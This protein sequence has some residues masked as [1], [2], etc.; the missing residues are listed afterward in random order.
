MPRSLHGGRH[1]LGQNFL[2]HRP[3]V[4]R[5]ASLV[6]RS[7]G[8]ILEIGAGDGALTRALA[9]L[10]RPLTAIEIDEHR[11][12]E[13]RRS[14]G[15]VRVEHADALRYPLLAPVLV[16]NIPFHLTTPL[17]RRLL[18]TGAWERAILLTQW[19]VARKRAGVGGGTMLTA[20]TAPWFSF[21]LHGR[22]PSWCFRPRPS[23][24]GG[25]LGISRRE[26]P[27]VAAAERG[28]YERFVR[29]LF[30]GRGRGLGGALTHAARLSR[31]DALRLIRR[32]GIDPRAL[33]RDLDAA[34]WAALWAA[35]R[36]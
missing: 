36:S 20:Q 26:R 29:S 34:Q 10:G 14:L 15:G 17:L 24:D 21:E 8:P 11:V 4:D 32:A 19:E 28:A 30:T 5:L 35:L 27:L 2:T 23:V 13:L 12:E 33:P 3:T 25:I 1:E 16:G 7:S 22:V 31:G 18:V 9:R 6:S